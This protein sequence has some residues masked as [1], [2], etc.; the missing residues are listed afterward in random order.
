MQDKAITPGSSYASRWPSLLSC[1]IVI[2][3]LRG[4]SIQRLSQRFHMN[5][6]KVEERLHWTETVKRYLP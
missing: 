1:V 2:L 6:P 5:E 3:H 4:W